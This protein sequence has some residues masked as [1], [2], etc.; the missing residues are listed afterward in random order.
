MHYYTMFT[1]YSANDVALMEFVD[2]L[3]SVGS[4]LADTP[5]ENHPCAGVAWDVAG[6]KGEDWWKAYNEKMLKAGQ[7]VN[8]ESSTTK[9]TKKA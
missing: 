8:E 5:L 1:E 4:D 7:V 6:W 2:D 3:R 9:V